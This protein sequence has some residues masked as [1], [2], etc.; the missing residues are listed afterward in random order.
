MRFILPA[1]LA[2]VA[3]IKAGALVPEVHLS[4]KLGIFNAIISLVRPNKVE[5]VGNLAKH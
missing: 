5:S 2:I 1:T 4:D 3:I